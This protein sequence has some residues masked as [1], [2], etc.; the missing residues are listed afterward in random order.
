MKK[1]IEELPSP[2]QFVWNVLT[3]LE[4]GERIRGVDLMERAGIDD[5]RQFY[6]VISDLR[7]EGFLV[8]SSKLSENGGYFEIRDRRDLERTAN[9]MLKTAQALLK[10][11]RHL[12][13]RFYESLYDKLAMNDDLEGE[14]KDDDK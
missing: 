4:D 5:R 12:E 9:D 13:E 2:H 8:G 6:H 10:T 3:L 7:T 11:K 1:K 14:T